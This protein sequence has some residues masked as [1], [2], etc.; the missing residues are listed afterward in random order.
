MKKSKRSLFIFCLSASFLVHCGV[1][2]WLHRHFQW[3]TVLSKPIETIERVFDIVFV[4]HE[5]IPE[6]IEIPSYI[7]KEEEATLSLEKPSL[8]SQETFKQD[9]HFPEISKEQIQPIF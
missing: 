9:V 1:V 3:N 8:L 5:K 2:F 6:K 7:P 4:K